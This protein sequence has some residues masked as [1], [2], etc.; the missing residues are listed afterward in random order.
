M[1]GIKGS[2]GAM[3]L[4]CGAEVKTKREIQAIGAAC[5]QTK[6]EGHEVKSLRNHFLNSN[7]FDINM[8]MPYTSTWQLCHG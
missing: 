6:Q 1:S 3:M 8:I 7:N 5:T 4:L 2:G